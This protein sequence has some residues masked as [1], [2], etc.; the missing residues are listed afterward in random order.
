MHTRG[1]FSTTEL[2]P[3][4]KSEQVVGESGSPKVLM[5]ASAA[6]LYKSAYIRAIR[7]RPVQPGGEHENVVGES[8]YAW[9][10]GTQIPQ[11]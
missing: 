6:S 1:I 5:R 4:W 3:H 7:V 10:N 9:H 2:P 8:R 11:I